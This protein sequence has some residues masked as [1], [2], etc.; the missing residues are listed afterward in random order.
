MT[1]SQLFS[2]RRALWTILWDMV[3][4]KKMV[5]SGS[6][7]FFQAAHR[8]DENL[9]PTAVGLTQIHIAALH[10]LVAAQ[11]DNAHRCSFLIMASRPANMRRGNGWLISIA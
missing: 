11:N 5:R 8:L 3:L 9:G 2:S 4:V 6:P 10:T 1:V 7:S